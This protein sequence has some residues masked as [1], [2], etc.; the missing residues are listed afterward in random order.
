MYWK[1]KISNKSIRDRIERQYTIDDEGEDVRSHQQDEG[2]S[3]GEDCD[4]V[5]GRRQSTTWETSTMM[6]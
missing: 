3:T 1:D 5:N 2:P 6:Y 4:A